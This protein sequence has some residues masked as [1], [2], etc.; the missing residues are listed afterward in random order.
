VKQP[1]PD[2]FWTPFVRRI[3][4]EETNAVDRE[5]KGLVMECPSV[6]SLVGLYPS[7]LVLKFPSGPCCKVRRAIVDTD[8]IVF[9]S[10]RLPTIAEA[11]VQLFRDEVFILSEN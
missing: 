1:A 3:E 2:S 9:L 4:R 8:K 7:Y 5:V 11:A 6:R 10:S